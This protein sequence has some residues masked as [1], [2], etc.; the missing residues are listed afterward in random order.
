MGVRIEFVEIGN[1]RKLLSTRI[2]ISEKQTIFVGANNS[3]KTSA[4]VALRR[5][6]V[7][8]ER[9]NFSLNDFTLSHWPTLSKMGNAWEKAHS[10]NTELPSPAWENVLPFLDVWLWVEDDEVRYVQKILPTLDWEGGRLGVRLRLEPSDSRKL[11]EEYLKARADAAAIKNINEGIGDRL[12]G[13]FGLSTADLTINLWPQNLPEFLQRRL[14]QF[15]VVRSYILDP[16]KLA[17]P[18]HGQAKPQA[19]DPRAA[20][21]DGD[22]LN[23]LVRIDEISAQRGFSQDARP[24]DGD[25]DNLGS[26]DATTRKLTDQLRRYYKRHLDPYHKPQ[27]QDLRALQAIEIAQKAFDKRLREGFATALNEMETL[28]YPG[29]TNPRLSISTRLRPVDG[30]NHDTAVQYVI[31]LVEDASSFDMRLPEESNGLGY[32]NLISMVFRLMSYRDAWMRVGKA[33]S[34][35]AT[36]EAFTPPLHLVLVEEPEAY[37]HTQV[38]QA[39]IRRAYDLLRN[40]DKLRDDTRL[41]TQLV[42]STHSS[43]IAHECEFASLRYFR[44]LPTK[45]GKIPIS[46]VVNLTNV[47]GEETET[48]RFVT[49]YLKV[50]HCDL[51]FA[52][53]A[54]FI[55]GPAE[56]ILVP[57]FVRNQDEFKDLAESYVTWLEIGGS[58]AHRL[59]DLV[60]KLG[61]TTLVITDLDATTADGASAVPARG[62]GQKTRNATMKTWLPGT[63]DLDELLAKSAAEKVKEYPGESLSVRVAYQSP[64]NI[65]FKSAS[66]EALA[67]T[68][69]DAL[70]Y[71]NLDLFTGFDGGGLGA[72]FRAAIASSTTL[73]DLA[74]ELT[75]QLKV[76]GKAELALELLELSDARALKPPTYIQEGLEWLTQRLRQDQTELGLPVAARGVSQAK[77]A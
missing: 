7:G 23:G 60:E 19:L 33:H 39:F 26:V 75:K 29:I 67:N 48:K 52:D 38:Q 22:P 25:E 55:E 70:V 77:A 24:T 9:A 43:H 15:F 12:E 45:A 69:E 41:R 57:H 56:R 8:R 47:F 3:G 27:E 64:V 28:G 66:S 16:V 11:Q 71:E 65:T 63:D 20:P 30:L 10:T 13:A 18:E 46:C 61:L 1:F 73:P 50:T 72:K 5:F 53:A 21:I 62:A 51:F 59:R 17:D 54:I 68:F 49:R 2:G 4:M 74:A 42:V 14:R 34:N 31:P 37:L 58:H 40:N 44:R 32:Q 36:L 6:L 76:G 35:G